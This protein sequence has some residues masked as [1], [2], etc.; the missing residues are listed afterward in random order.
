MRVGSDVIAV[1]LNS[2]TYIKARQAVHAREVFNVTSLAV[3]SSSVPR[4]TDSAVAVSL[5]KI[6]VN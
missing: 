4:A 1:L 5:K 2:V 6:Y 3:E